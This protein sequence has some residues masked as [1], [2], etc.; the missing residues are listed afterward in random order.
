MSAK[1]LSK[2]YVKTRGEVYYQLHLTYTMDII[3][4]I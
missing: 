1:A 2:Y 4:F 3:Y